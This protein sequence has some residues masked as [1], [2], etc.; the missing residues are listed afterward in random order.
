[1]Y[2]NEEFSISSFF[3]LVILLFLLAM[4]SIPLHAQEMDIDPPEGPNKM[5]YYYQDSGYGALDADV[6][7]PWRG[8]LIGGDH[9]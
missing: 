1:M 7:L 6:T 5:D 3:S 8:T 2:E 9:G 4:F